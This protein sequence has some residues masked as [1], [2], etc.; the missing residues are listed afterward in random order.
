MSGWLL[1][2]G[3]AHVLV[4]LFVVIVTL[5]TVYTVLSVFG[6]VAVCCDWLHHRW[7]EGLAIQ[8]RNMYRMA[9]FTA[10]WRTQLI[11]VLC[12]V[13]NAVSRRRNGGEWQ[14][15][16]TRKLQYSVWYRSSWVNL[17]HNAYNAVF[18]ASTNVNQGMLTSTNC[19]SLHGGRS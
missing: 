8:K 12:R 7:W 16:S 5:L 18:C 4:L 3:Y 11:V 6:Y 13:N 17:S 9:D 19:K 1:V 14:S 15:S 10:H 2:N